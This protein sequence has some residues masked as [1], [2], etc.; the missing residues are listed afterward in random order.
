[1]GKAKPQATT[2]NTSLG[3]HK[4]PISTAKSKNNKMRADAKTLKSLWM[5]VEPGRGEFVSKVSER[6]SFFHDDIMFLHQNEPCSHLIVVI[7]F[8]GAACRFWTFYQ[9]G[10][11]SI[12]WRTAVLYRRDSYYLHWFVH[13]LLLF[14]MENL[15]DNFLKGSSKVSVEN[16]V[17]QR[18]SSRVGPAQP[19]D[20]LKTIHFS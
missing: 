5:S 3:D 8:C 20:C 19:G 7:K 2:R 4:T 9:L 1:M 12:S 10:G 16:A 6:L 17:Y 11:N 13:V 18:I 14:A 15:Y